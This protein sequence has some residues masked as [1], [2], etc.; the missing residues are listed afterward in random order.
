MDWP[1][2]AV[3]LAERGRPDLRGTEAEA[4]GRRMYERYLER[5]DAVAL[6]A[7]N[8]GTVVGFLDMAFRTWLNFT[9]PQAWTP[10]LVV[11]EGSRGQRIGEALL[12][13]AEQIARAR[14][15]WSMALESATWRDRAP[16]LLL[17]ARMEGDRPSLYQ[18][19]HRR[20]VAAGATALR[21][22]DRSGS[23]PPAPRMAT[24]WAKRH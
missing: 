4:E 7:E 23:S 3:L 18:T 6:V 20:A 22:T 1:A 19:A 16:L 15:C 8:D 14:G 5:P 12:A 24:V 2:V 10:D 21:R 9:P 11:A 17:V 13:R